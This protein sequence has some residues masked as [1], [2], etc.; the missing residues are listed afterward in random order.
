M[1]RVDRTAAAP[2]PRRGG[3]ARATALAATLAL[4]LA[5]GL[6]APS[7][8]GDEAAVVAAERALE[9]GDVPTALNAFRALADAED[10]RRDPRVLA[11]LASAFLRAGSPRDALDPCA[12]VVR[13]RGTA[14]DRVAYAEALLAVAKAAVAAGPRSGLEVMPY[15][16]DALAQLA[17]VREP[18]ADVATHAARVEGEARWLLGD[19]AGARAALAAPGLASDVAAQ[20]LA[21][22]AAYAMG[23]WAA[24]AA[25]WKVAGHARGVALARALAKDPGAVDAYAAL[26]RAAPTDLEL[27]DEASR[28]AVAL[29]AV[30]AFDAALAEPEPGTAAM[31]RLRGRLLER[32]GRLGPAVARYRAAKD[33]APDDT[34]VLADFARARL[35]SA[36]D[37]VA[38]V[39][40][41]VAAF[42]VVL[43][44]RPDDAWARQGLE[45]VARRDA[46]AV[47]REWPDRR[48]LD[49]MVA[50][51]RAVAEAD[52]SDGT[53]WV[54]LGNARRT[55]GDLD[56]A[57]DAFERAVAGNPY[58]AGAWN[59]RGIAL[60]AAGR[61]ADARASYA[62][63][64]ELDPGAVAP[65]QN[66]AR[67][68]R[69]AGDLDAADGHATAALATA[70]VLGGHPQ[71][72]RSIQDRVWRAR[73]MTAR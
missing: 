44:K 73:R 26:V 9:A 55:A 71:L 24:A 11:G 52:P 72:Y 18:T 58:D 54:N 33:L 51:L 7:A 57:L 64:I 27:A 38:A 46:D 19:A 34:E 32:A 45:F 5:G 4:G 60:A 14:A 20:D 12:A 42:V 37:D 65:H 67:L 50:A 62:R 53:A 8:R 15:L 16:R 29:E 47:P 21:A 36:P 1:G 49:R 59:D 6:P 2:R 70:R 3:L 63:A 31:Q 61:P 43:A 35:A 40:E 22:R 56:G 13:L 69:L 17:A 48:R 28:A 41:A 30:D 10:G 66:A 39:D 68:A 25:A 23:D